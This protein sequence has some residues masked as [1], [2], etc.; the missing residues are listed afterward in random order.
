MSGPNPFIYYPQRDKWI[1]N[2]IKDNIFKEFK[3]I[4]ILC[5]QDGAKYDRDIENKKLNVDVIKNYI[6]LKTSTKIIRDEDKL[7]NIMTIKGEIL[8]KYFPQDFTERELIYPFYNLEYSNVRSFCTQYEGVSSLYDYIVINTVDDY[9]NHT[10]INESERIN[11][12]LI[13]KSMYEAKYWTKKFNCNQNI[14]IKFNTRLFS[15]KDKSDISNINNK[16]LFE[17]ILNQKYD[18]TDYLGL[19]YKIRSYVDASS[20]DRR[21]LYYITQHSTLGTLSIDNFNKL[22]DMMISR[23]YKNEFYYLVM[24][25]MVSKELCHLII[26][27]RYILELL[28]SKLF[29]NDIN[30]LDKY[31]PIIRYLLSYVWLSFYHEESIKKSYINNSDRFIFNIE[32]ASL[33]PNF[34][35]DPYDPVTSPYLPLMIAMEALDPKKNTMGVRLEYSFD[36]NNVDYGYGVCNLEEFR[37]RMNIFITG[38]DINILENINWSNIGITGSI[39]AACLPRFN[40]LH[41]NFMDQ[42]HVCNMVDFFNEYYSNA[43]IDVICTLRSF[44]FIDK[45][46]EIVKTLESNI[47]ERYN[48]ADNDD[49]IICEPIKNATIFFDIDYANTYL[50]DDNLSLQDIIANTNDVRVINKVYPMYVEQKEIFIKEKIDTSEYN[51][52]KYEPYFKIVPIEKI[53][54]NLYKHKDNKTPDDDIIEFKNIR[55]GENLKFKVRSEYIPRVFE[56]FNIKHQDI[57]GTVSQFHLPSVRAYYNGNTVKLLPSCISAC[58]TLTHIDYKYFAGTNDPI[59][60]INKYRQ[61]GFG[62]FLNT[63]EMI[64]MCDYSSKIDKWITAYN[65]D[66]NIKRSIINFLDYKKYTD[67]FFHPFTHKIINYDVMNDYSYVDV[68]YKKFK[69]KKTLDKNLLE[70]KCIDKNG[71]VIPYED[72][73]VEYGYHLL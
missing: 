21:K 1:L 13:L 72:W 5:L 53:K 46:Y 14:T 64:R 36:N 50:V 31:A 28:N 44:D 59:E 16:E 37:R 30:Y 25:T 52:P 70:L 29:N 23:N 19:I 57:F 35:Y 71:F 54:V 49:V 8:S 24:N 2:E 40:P 60:I 45:V 34:P 48:L 26:N 15:L 47:R 33:L 65:L 27:N 22:V 39:M 10:Y 62:T 11:R 38:H 56:I 4:Y 3:H 32:T 67:K 73:I 17:N 68:F 55:F 18:D 61:R 9:T 6:L 12:L 63:E 58:M 69:S 7:H 41:M 43:D 51:N 66:I 20:Y 42:D